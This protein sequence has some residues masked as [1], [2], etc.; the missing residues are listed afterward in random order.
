M[1]TVDIT[2]KYIRLNIYDKNVA[3]INGIRR[4]MLNHVPC[5]GFVDMMDPAD[6]KLLTGTKEE[7]RHVVLVDTLR[8]QAIPILARRCS[9]IPIY[10]SAET[11][12][13]LKSTAERKIFFAIC[14]K[15]DDMLKSISRPY[16]HDNTN[17]IKRIYSRDLIP[18]VLTARQSEE[19]DKAEDEAEPVMIYDATASQAVM[20]M[21]TEIFPYNMLIA[22]MTY[23]DKLNVILKPTEGIGI[24]NACWSPCTFSYRFMMDPGWIG[25]GEA[26]YDQRGVLRR[27]IQGEKSIRELFTTDPKTMKP[28]NRLGKPYGIDIMFRNN[29]KMDHVQ[30]FLKSIEVLQNGVDLFLDQYLK[31]NTEGSV[32]AKET[33]YL[34]GDN[35]E[36]ASEAE[37][38]YVPKNTADKLADKE[39][40]LAGHTLGNILTTKML[41]IVSDT[42]TKNESLMLQKGNWKEVHIAYMIPH[43]QIKQS[44]I[45]IKL[46]KSLNIVHVDLVQQATRDIKK[47]LDDLSILI[48]SAI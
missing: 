30:A 21:M 14:E 20:D 17:V 46:P 19:V 18:V 35:E 22:Q 38:M 45:I 40:I 4:T 48:S 24:N 3:T 8:S 13:V 36:H 26:L 5:Y 12:D 47:D 7:T 33:T 31:A 28:Y 34:A 6:Y 39:L 11:V 15:S 29:G 10:T 23:G 32:I 43:P 42:L 1:S 9:R 2:S 27:K 16:I 41:E 37:I 44:R 25:A